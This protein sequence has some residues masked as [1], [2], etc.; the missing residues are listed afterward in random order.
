MTEISESTK[1]VALSTNGGML[2]M[3]TKYYTPSQLALVPVVDALTPTL[4]SETGVTVRPDFHRRLVIQ[5]D[6]L[7]V[8]KNGDLAYH[9]RDAKRAA[10]MK[11]P[12][13][14]YLRDALTALLS[15]L[16]HQRPRCRCYDSYAS[17]HEPACPV[18]QWEEALT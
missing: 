8:P 15:A 5:L 12:T 3:E 18:R 16:G 4:L 1:R 9:I 13:T 7:A 17:R 10:A 11:N 6:S 2:N 14:G